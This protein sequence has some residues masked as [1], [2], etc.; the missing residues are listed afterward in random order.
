RRGSAGLQ[1]DRAED[2][3]AR[4]ELGLGD[5]DA[6]TLRGREKLGAADVRTAAQHLGWHADEHLLRCLR[7]LLRPRQQRVDR[8][9]RLPQEGAEGVPSL[10][11]PG[12]EL[13]YRGPGALQKARRLGGIELRGR[14]VP[15]AR[16]RDL[17]RLLLD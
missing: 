2:R 11:E 5:T 7:N 4:I 17:Q 12:R 9:G 16:L 10:L 13:G 6:G 14:P 15:E 1:A 3:E 8:T